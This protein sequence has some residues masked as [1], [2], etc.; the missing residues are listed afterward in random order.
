MNIAFW[1]IQFNQIPY[2]KKHN[3]GITKIDIFVFIIN[4][5][6]VFCF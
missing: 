6:T 5:L 1:N 3:I 2:P 4:L